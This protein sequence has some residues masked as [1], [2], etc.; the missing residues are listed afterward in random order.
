[1]PVHALHATCTKHIMVLV[2]SRC[3]VQLHCAVLVACV[4]GHG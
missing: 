3:Q 2:A 4:E 1:M